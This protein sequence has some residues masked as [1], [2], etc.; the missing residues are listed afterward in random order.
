MSYRRTYHDKVVA[1]GSKTVSVHYPASEHGGTTSTTVYFEETVPLE[2]NIVVDT[3]NFDRSITNAKISV[4][5]LTGAVTAMEAAQ[6][7]AI[8]NS[9]RDI[10]QAITNGFYRLIG[11]ELTTQISE[12]KSVLQS[13]I[14]LIMELSKDIVEKHGRMSDDMNRLKRHYKEIFDGLDEDCEKRVLALD[15]ASFLL[16]QT[17]DEL[18]KAPYV[19]GGPFACFELKDTAN[20]QNL[21]MIARLKNKVSG[22]LNVMTDAAWHT[23]KYMSDVENL[24]S[25]IPVEQNQKYSV[26]VVFVEEANMNETGK[27]TECFANAGLNDKEGVEAQ[28]K[29]YVTSAQ[30]DSWKDLC[31]FDMGMIRQSFSAVAEEDLNNSTDADKQ[32]VFDQIMRMWNANTLKTL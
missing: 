28:V 22:V 2:F 9:S 31:E 27:V 8:E 10:S 17:R 5:S 30:A 4:D 1:R 16:S 3:D 19:S 6:C 24:S 14:A 23:Q 13:K 12:N 15:K 18:I 11:S 21:S 29:N 26:P 32:R 20:S 7:K 25:S